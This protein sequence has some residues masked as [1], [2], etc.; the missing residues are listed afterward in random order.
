MK[1]KRGEWGWL[2]SIFFIALLV[3]VV[4]F[5]V[6][7]LISESKTSLFGTFKG[8]LERLGFDSE[9]DDS[10][11]TASSDS[12]TTSERDPCQIKRFYWSTK[13]A[14]IGEAV[15]IIV[16]GSENCNGERIGIKISKDWTGRFLHGWKDEVLSTYTSTFDKNK[17]TLDWNVINP[18]RG[19]I[20][21]FRGYY[22]T[23]TF[24]ES[25]SSKSS[26]L[27]IE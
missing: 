11:T 13:R 2:A 22:F 1:N 10:S 20:T 19:Y 26:R 7:G 24:K 3:G 27:E 15:K 25:E 18:G 23:Y 16:E 21:K 9:A 6:F 5:I 17:A 8:L 12:E 14:T 4:A